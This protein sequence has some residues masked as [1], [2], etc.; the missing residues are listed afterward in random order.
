MSK[1]SRGKNLNRR[2]DNRGD[3]KNLKGVKTCPNVPSFV[4]RV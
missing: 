4:C 2:K 1:L 3:V